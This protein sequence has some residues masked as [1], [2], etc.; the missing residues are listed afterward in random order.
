MSEMMSYKNDDVYEIQD[1][2]K[3]A[4]QSSMTEHI[5][6]SALQETEDDEP[7]RS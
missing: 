2:C 6:K 3:Y 7:G 1:P 4:T 5:A